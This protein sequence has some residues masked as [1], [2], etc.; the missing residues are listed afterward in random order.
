M[1]DD[2]TG[3]R[4]VSVSRDGTYCSIA[5]NNGK[6]YV[7]KMRQ[8]EAHHFEHITTIDAHSKYILK[9]VFSPDTTYVGVYSYS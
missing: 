1:P 5:S 8:G 4:S 9:C 7:Y 2:E 6:V 3:I